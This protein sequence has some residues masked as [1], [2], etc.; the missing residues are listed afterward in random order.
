[1]DFFFVDVGPL[2]HDQTL[3]EQQELE[4]V[5]CAKATFLYVHVLKLI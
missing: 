5:A 2:V 1:M 4:L 3:M